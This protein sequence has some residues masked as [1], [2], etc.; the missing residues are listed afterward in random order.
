MFTLV[1]LIRM[2]NL[3]LD[4]QSQESNSLI[5]HASVVSQS[6]SSLQVVTIHGFR[7]MSLCHLRLTTHSQLLLVQHQSR[8]KRRNLRKKE[9]LHSKIQNLKATVLE[10][11]QFKRNP[12]AT[13]NALS[14][15]KSYRTNKS[16]KKY[17][18]FKRW[19]L[20]MLSSISS[21]LT[22]RQLSSTDSFTLR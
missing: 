12:L 22:V 16:L 8:L 18:L 15:T 7:S 11:L 21:S 2:A 13:K 9:M 14:K 1:V 4:T 6:I 3:V 19:L 5:W 17:C 20:R 10:V